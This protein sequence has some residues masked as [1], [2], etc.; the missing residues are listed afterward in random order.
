MMRHK[1]VS[2]V[3]LQ[4]QGPPGVSETNF[5]TM[6]HCHIVS[7]I[8]DFACD[9]SLAVSESQ[10]FALALVAVYDITLQLELV[11]TYYLVTFHSN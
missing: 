10:I 8:N 6:C 4:E 5:S 1:S 3:E 7:F 2:Q 11:M 9:H